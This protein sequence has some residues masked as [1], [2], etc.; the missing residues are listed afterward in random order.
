MKKKQ[1]LVFLGLCAAGLT[2]GHV[3]KRMSSSPAAPAATS[4]S[5]R[6][7]PSGQGGSEESSAPV[8]KANTIAAARSTLRSKDTLESIKTAEGADLYARVALWMVD[9]S[10]EDITSYWQ[11]YR[12]QENRS[13]E[14]NDLIFINWTRINPQGATA[15]AKGT[16]DEHYAWWAWACH[17]PA[18]ALS[19]AIATNPDRVNNVTWG[20]GE[21][22]PEWLREH[23]DE[24]PEESRDNALQGLA[25][26]SDSG[27][28]LEKLEFFSK[29]GRGTHP[30][31]FKVLAMRD[32]WAAYDWLTQNASQ[33]DI[34]YYSQDDPLSSF[35]KIAGT[36]HPDVLKR[37]VE[38]APAGDLKRKMEGALFKSLLDTDPDAAI[39]QA[40]ETKAPFVASQR[41]AVAA[42][43]FLSTDPDKA[44]ELAADLFGA[45]P[46]AMGQYKTVKV[47]NSTMH[48]GAENQD[49][50]NLVNAML[51]KDPARLIE[52]Q[53]P[54]SESDGQ[55][56]SGFSNLANHWVEADLAGFAEWTKQQ[57]DPLVR[58]QATINIVNKLRGENDFAGAAGWAAIMSEQKGY[59]E[60]LMTDW[61]RT[62]PQA[63]GTWLESSGLPTERL[64]KLRELIGKE[65]P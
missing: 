34:Y 19:T 13:N 22:H 29:Q 1:T 30:G 24:L 59:L 17:D 8:T 11:H 38:Q 40:R 51:A 64:D 45:S 42:M 26:W 48:F 47:A 44:F 58:D 56:M 54:T 49:V 28:P 20:I 32:P 41:L 33:R 52:M 53:L 16:P 5:P 43:H 10:E 37:I 18:T 39:Q 6:S 3:V 25:K 46:N 55:R 14:I 60:N 2:T 62:D 12:Q 31:V 9:A 61:V 23:F 57:S 36:E 7:Q 35:L 63:A 50:N 65:A 27:D 4:S 15:A 21:F